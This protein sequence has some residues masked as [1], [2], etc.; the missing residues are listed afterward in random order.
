MNTYL[1]AYIIY[2]FAH[3]REQT[4]AKTKRSSLR[5]SIDLLLVPAEHVEFTHAQADIRREVGGEFSAF[6]GWAS[7]TTV[8]LIPHKKIVQ[9]W[10]GPIGPKVIIPR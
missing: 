9:K 6:D 5:N 3:W 4:P 7:I 8:E 10:R 2:S 1:Y